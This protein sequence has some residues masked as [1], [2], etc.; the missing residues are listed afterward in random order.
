MPPIAEW[1]FV[2]RRQAGPVPKDVVAAISAALETFL[3]ADQTPAAAEPIIPWGLAG[4]QEGVGGP[5][6]FA[7]AEGVARHPLEK[8]SLI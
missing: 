1:D 5:A 2:G 4:R 8:T 7:R 3:S 6:V